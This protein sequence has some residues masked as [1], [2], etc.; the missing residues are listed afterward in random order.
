MLELGDFDAALTDSE[1]S[2]RAGAN[3]SFHRFWVL[4]NMAFIRGDFSQAETEWRRILQMNPAC[5]ATQIVEVA[6]ALVAVRKG[7]LDEG[8]RVLEKFRDRPGFGGNHLIR[9]AAAVG[10]DR[11]RNSLGAHQSVLRQLPLARG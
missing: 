11:F 5:D 7:Q 9:L 2:G 8:K 1:T 4:G 6:L 3:E 10:D